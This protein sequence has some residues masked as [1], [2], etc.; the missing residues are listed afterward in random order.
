LVRKAV[1]AER[2]RLTGK[3][4]RKVADTEAGKAVQSQMGAPTVLVNRLVKQAA[5]EVLKRSPNS[6]E[7]PHT[8]EQE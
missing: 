6:S 1:A 8:A 2:Q 4:K 7:R 3:K 5:T